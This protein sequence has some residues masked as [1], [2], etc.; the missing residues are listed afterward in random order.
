[1]HVEVI[2]NSCHSIELENDN[3]V[4]QEAEAVDCYNVKPLHGACKAA[5]EEHY[6]PWGKWLVKVEV[7]F[8]LRDGLPS[9]QQSN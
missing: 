8:V 2:S 9:C 1:M 6:Q 7:L 3:Y 4:G 5:K